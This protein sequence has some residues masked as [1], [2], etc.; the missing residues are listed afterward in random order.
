M[1]FLGRQRKIFQF[2]NV[3]EHLAASAS[4]Y[5]HLLV[6]PEMAKRL[7]LIIS[8]RV[9]WDWLGLQPILDPTFM[10]FHRLIPQ[11][12][13]QTHQNCCQMSC[14]QAGSH[15]PAVS[16]A[17]LP[18]AERPQPVPAT[19]EVLAVVTQTGR[20]SRKL[21]QQMSGNGLTQRRDLGPTK[22][23]K[24]LVTKKNNSA[25]LQMHVWFFVVCVCVWPFCKWPLH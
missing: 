17:P 3:A 22:C 7:S 6:L 10:M 8:S 12:E 5:L 16:A 21:H 2:L 4:L 15:S 14:G 23:L 20:F 11:V 19:G 18:G 9:P 25:H 1:A 13:K 24:V